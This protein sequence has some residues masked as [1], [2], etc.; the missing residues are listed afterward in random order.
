MPVAGIKNFL[1][2]MKRL[3][4][5]R[6]DV[7]KAVVTHLDERN[8]YNDIRTNMQILGNL[9]FRIPAGEGEGETEDLK[10][11]SFSYTGI[12]TKQ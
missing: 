1:T 3:R 4:R 11:T 5:A 8:A 6:G 2:A 9:N 12:K 7:V 10:S